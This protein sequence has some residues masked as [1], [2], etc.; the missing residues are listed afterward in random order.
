M[1]A[2]LMDMLYFLRPMDQSVLSAWTQ[3][4]SVLQM[5]GYS[6]INLQICLLLTICRAVLVLQDIL[7]LTC[8][9]EI[10]PG[11]TLVL[12]I[13]PSRHIGYSYRSRVRY[14]HFSG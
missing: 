8:L 3:K 2:G 10:V 9:L 14:E 6:N 5:N 4:E 13:L 1:L 12:Q 7:V 11:A